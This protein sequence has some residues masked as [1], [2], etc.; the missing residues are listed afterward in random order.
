MP[1]DYPPALQKHFKKHGKPAYYDRV[2]AIVDEA[3]ENRAM[4]YSLLEER[5]PTSDGHKTHEVLDALDAIT[6]PSL[7]LAMHGGGK[8]NSAELNKGNLWEETMREKGGGKGNFFDMLMG[9]GKG[10][11]KGELLEMMM[12]AKGGGKG[13]DFEDEMQLPKGSV[14]EKTL[15]KIFG[16]SRRC[17]FFQTKNL[18]RPTFFFV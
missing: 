14:E 13:F 1:S 5:L 6:N 7:Y 16:C 11:G 12:Q 3:G 4:V 9:K 15:K 17:E 10:G 2:K 8:G 18:M